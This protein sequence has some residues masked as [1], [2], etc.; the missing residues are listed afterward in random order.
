MDRGEV[1]RCTEH[2]GL[3]RFQKGYTDSANEMMFVNIRMGRM[4]LRVYNDAGLGPDRE[5]VVSA[6][7]KAIVTLKRLWMIRWNYKI[8]YND[9]LIRH[10]LT[11]IKSHYV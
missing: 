10:F 3:D 5:L 11:L 7:T 8:V 4:S 1:N 6:K 2:V 9:S